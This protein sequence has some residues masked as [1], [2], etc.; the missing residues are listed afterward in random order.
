MELRPL[1]AKVTA[2][3][4]SAKT[5][6]D[7]ATSVYICATA[8]VLI[9]NHTTGATLQMHEDQAIVLQK[10]AGDELFASS[11]NAHFTKVAYPRG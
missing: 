9:T 6:V 8:D 2:N 10:A 11:A 4:S 7:L 3:T 5:N 1:N